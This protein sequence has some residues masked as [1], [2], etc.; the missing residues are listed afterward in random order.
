MAEDAT[1]TSETTGWPDLGYASYDSS[2][3]RFPFVGGNYNS[4]AKVRLFHAFVNAYSTNSSSY[5]C[6]RLS[7]RG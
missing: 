2:S 5:Y 6:A 1:T 4:G 3:A 7:F